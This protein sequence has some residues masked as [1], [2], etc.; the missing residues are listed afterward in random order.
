MKK[1]SEYFTVIGFCA[2][3]GILALL[4]L[5]LPD[6]D[7]SPQENRA[8]KQ[9]PALTGD[10]FFSGEF[11]QE[12][13]SYFADQ[14]PARNVFVKMKG[15]AELLFLKGEN[16]GV[17]Y[18]PHQLAVKD[19]NAYRSRIHIS[20]N[21]DRIYLQSAQA[22][23]QAV[24]TFAEN[25]PVPVVTVLPPRTVDIADS[26]FSYDRPDGDALFALMEQELVSAGYVDSLSL[27]RPRFEAGEYVYYRT[28]HHW[29]TLGAYYTYAEIMKELGKEDEVLPMEAF[30]VEQISDF[31]G[32]TAAKAGFPLYEKDTLELW[33]LPDEENYRVLADGKELQGFY[34]R[35]FLTGSD[36]YSVFLDGTHNLT[37]ITKKGEAREKLL[38]A[39]DSFANCLIPFL[40]AH[41][42][43]VAVNLRGNTQLSALAQEHS[44]QAVLIVYNAENIITSGDLGNIR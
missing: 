32:T 28:D 19:F 24:N 26:T 41:Y 16:N 42:D 40:A 7:F 27:L 13:N 15:G 5:I 20:E 21:T 25:S 1:F 10:S 31:S 17:L 39:K 22:Q 30:T 12:V 4:F 36:K 37:L 3:L 29:T 33:H 14:F 35:A 44:A 8:L 11:S 23:F 34:A 2:T 43:I 18:S 6:K 38:V 9:W